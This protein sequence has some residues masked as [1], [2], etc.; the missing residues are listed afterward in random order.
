MTLTLIAVQTNHIHFR[1]TNILNIPNLLYNI[2]LGVNGPI[3]VSRPEAPR[4]KVIGSLRDNL[5]A[6]HE[7][8]HMN[9]AVMR[10]PK[11]C[12]ARITQDMLKKPR[13]TLPNKLHI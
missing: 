8:R 2:A 3:R 6:L 1:T 11:I 13:L 5:T 4:S 9:V 7:N 10:T 12:R